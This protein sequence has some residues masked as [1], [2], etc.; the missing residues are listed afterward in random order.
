[1]STY[2]ARVYWDK[3]ERD[4]MYDG[5]CS[6]DRHLMHSYLGSKRHN[7]RIADDRFDPSFLDELVLRGYDIT[8]LRMSVVC[9]RHEWIYAGATVW[10]RK[11]GDAKRVH[12]VR[13]ERGAGQVFLVGPSAKI[14]ALTLQ[15]ARMWYADLASVEREYQP[16]P[17]Q[18][19]RAML[20]AAGAGL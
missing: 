5:P 10:H 15:D 14:D 20:V 2:K 8:T 9:H 18:D 7:G 19:A 1:M 3:K 12:H 11:T 4:I 13:Y 16:E 6:P 17:P